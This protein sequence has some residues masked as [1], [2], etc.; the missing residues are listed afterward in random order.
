MY[1]VANGDSPVRAKIAAASHG[2]ITGQI[3]AANT[4]VLAGIRDGKNVVETA[5]RPAQIAPCKS[6]KHIVLFREMPS[7]RAK[8]AA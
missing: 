7:G 1:S 2:A 8:A 3:L 5:H 4:G 6:F